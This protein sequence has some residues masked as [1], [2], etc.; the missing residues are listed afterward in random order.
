LVAIFGENVHIKAVAGNFWSNRGLYMQVIL[1]VGWGW[2]LYMQ[3]A[4]WSVARL[5]MVW[6]RLR[7]G[8][9]STSTSGFFYP[10]K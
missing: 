9:A 5:I 6:H 3:Q 10:S 7:G 8:S 4:K 1:F 2:G